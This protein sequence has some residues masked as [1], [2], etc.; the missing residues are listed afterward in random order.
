MQS[1]AKHIAPIAIYTR[2]GPEARDAREGARVE[3]CRGGGELL[4]EG[5]PPT[6]RGPHSTDNVT[7]FNP[8]V[9]L[10][11]RRLQAARKVQTVKVRL[12][13]LERQRGGRLGRRRT[14]LRRD[15][16]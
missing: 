14:R 15:G 3:S 5:D 4:R 6:V 1:H 16:R 12:L 2:G 7:F 11:L 13:S 10:Y 9:L 8:R